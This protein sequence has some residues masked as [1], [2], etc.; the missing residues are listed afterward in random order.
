MARKNVK[1]VIPTNADDL[2]QLAQDII[3][4]HTADGAASPLNGLDMTAFETRVSNAA[5]KNALQKQLRRDAEMA[6]E[7]RD[8]LLGKRKDQNVN[9][10]GTVVNVSARV[11][12]ILLGTLKGNEQQLG[13]WGYQV[14]Q[15]SKSNGGS[16]TGSGDTGSGGNQT[17]GGTVNGMV[18]S[19]N[20]SMP[21]IKASVQV[22]GTSGSVMTSAGGTFSLTK[23]P[24]G[25]QTLRVSA[26]GYLQTDVPV[27][28]TN[29]G[30][31]TV[32][33]QLTPMP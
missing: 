8:G 28:V 17:S 5:A 32:N 22:L 16:N 9:T 10:D 24:A 11:R 15:S 7:D 33:V 3:A 1:V 14:N 25:P 29:N 30:V 13:Q 31:I 26:A 20:G 4:K 12:D 21:I 19:M 18:S 27:V 2:I 23:V 6:T